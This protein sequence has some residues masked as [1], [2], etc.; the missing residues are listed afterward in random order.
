ML[1][2]YVYHVDAKWCAVPAMDG[3]SDPTLS[4]LGSSRV[5]V[6][7]TT[8]SSR[9]WLPQLRGMALVL[10]TPPNELL[11]SRRGE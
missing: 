10:I 7:M 1:A 8:S 5:C 6:V 4:M 2:R 9:L 3:S 11:D